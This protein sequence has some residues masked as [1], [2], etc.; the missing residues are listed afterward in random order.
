MKSKIVL[1]FLL[2]TLNTLAQPE[3]ELAQKPPLGWNSF[4]SYGVYLHEKAAYENLDAF[5]KKLK[6]SGYEYFVIDAGWWGEY[7]L[8][9]GTLFPAEKT[10]PKSCHR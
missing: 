10:C 2:I 9:Q 6:P 8:V 4:D 5:V 3:Y 7:E 1:L